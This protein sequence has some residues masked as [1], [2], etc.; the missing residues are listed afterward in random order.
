MSA[1]PASASGRV[2]SLYSAVDR[3]GVAQQGAFGQQFAGRRRVA[4]RRSSP[5]TAFIPEIASAAL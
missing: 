4:G 2:I 1:G 5:A 3:R